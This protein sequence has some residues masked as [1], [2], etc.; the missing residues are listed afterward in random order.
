[1]EPKDLV[2]RDGKSPEP[3]GNGSGRLLPDPYRTALRSSQV[4]NVGGRE[5][6]TVRD[7]SIISNV[8][9][10]VAQVASNLLSSGNH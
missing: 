7:S 10:R 5:N 6:D 1:V 4:G 3:F 8:T 2:L 9:D